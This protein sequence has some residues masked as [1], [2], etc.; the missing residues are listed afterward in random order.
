MNL[1][2]QDTF[3]LS[4]FGGSYEDMC[5][6]MLW[7]G[8]GFLAEVNPPTEMWDGAKEFKDIYG[9]MITE[10]K[11]LKALDSVI[12][13]PGEDCTGA[14]HQCVMG[15]LRFIHQNGIEKW[16]AELAPHRTDPGDTFTWEGSLEAGATDGNSP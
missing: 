14:M 4:G 8:V 13:K 1:A 5:Q 3:S 9:V 12:V 10:G 11:H 7:R 2:R 6:R 15:H 16:R